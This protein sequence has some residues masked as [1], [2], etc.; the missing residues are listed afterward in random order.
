MCTLL[1]FFLT[2]TQLLAIVQFDVKVPVKAHAM[3]LSILR[4]RLLLMFKLFEPTKVSSGM[5][6]TCI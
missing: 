3:R 1:T 5:N 4:G 2:Q 6:A